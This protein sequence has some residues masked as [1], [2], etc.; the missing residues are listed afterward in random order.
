MGN[1]QCRPR[2]GGENLKGFLGRKFH[3]ISG[4]RKIDDLVT[5]AIHDDEEKTGIKRGV[6]ETGKADEVDDHLV[7]MALVDLE[8]ETVSEDELCP[9]SDGRSSSNQ[10]QLDKYQMYDD[11]NE[12][13]EDDCQEKP[14]RQDV[15]EHKEENDNIR[16]LQQQLQQVQNQLANLQRGASSSRQSVSARIN[17]DE[18][19]S[20]RSFQSQQPDEIKG[21]S[22][23]PR[24]EIFSPIETVSHRTPQSTFL[25][26]QCDTRDRLDKQYKDDHTDNVSAAGKKDAT[27]TRMTRI[28]SNDKGD[29]RGKDDGLAQKHGRRSKMQGMITE[30]LRS[31]TD[32][33]IARNK[34]V[35]T[36][37]ESTQN[38]KTVKETNTVIDKARISAK[39]A[40]LQKRDHALPRPDKGIVWPETM[41]DLSKVDKAYYV[42]QFLRSELFRQ[43]C[44]RKYQGS[45]K[46]M[47]GLTPFHLWVLENEDTAEIEAVL[48]P[49]P[50][51]QNNAQAKVRCWRGKTPPPL[52]PKSQ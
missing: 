7:D 31:R 29:A 5:V 17:Q 13:T 47:N 41:D 50:K 6:V 37:K 22:A 34:D 35:M 44:L 18:R 32:V 38:N 28:K 39:I 16:V 45:N 51:R 46:W 49:L 23:V 36:K 40:A 42:E 27:S 48:H 15:F 43:R 12:K 1:C 4:K 30:G 21:T 10:E 24:C 19:C 33:N 3:K 52:P 11:L 2:E 9:D 26:A 25:H 8:C 14:S 20:A